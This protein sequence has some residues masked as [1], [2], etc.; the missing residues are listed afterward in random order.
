MTAK[1]NVNRRLVSYDD[2][3]GML[4]IFNLHFSIFNFKA[5]SAPH[6]G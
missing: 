5:L 3:F 4:L 6:A 1:L 2:N